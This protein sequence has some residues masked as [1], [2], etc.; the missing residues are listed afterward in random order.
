VPSCTR[1]IVAFDGAYVRS[2]LDTGPYQHSVVAGR[3]E[4]DGILAGRFVW[5]GEAEQFLKA[6]LQANGWTTQT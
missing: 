3:I 4:R 6:A 1:L 5:P 2:N